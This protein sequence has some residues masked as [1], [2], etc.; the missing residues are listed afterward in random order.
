MPDKGK[1]GRQTKRLITRHALDRLRQRVGGDLQCHG[2]GQ[3]RV[4]LD[5]I[6]ED[7]IRSDAFEMVI[8][9]DGDPMRLV[10]LGGQLGG[11][12]AVVK[13]SADRTGPR[14]EAVVTVLTGEMVECRLRGDCYVRLAVRRLEDAWRDRLAPVAA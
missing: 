3:L 8:G 1:N 9:P 12:R 10:D 14:R 7:S 2:D 4:V 13:L 5:A 6:V 11:A